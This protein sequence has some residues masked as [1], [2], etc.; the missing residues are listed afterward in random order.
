MTHLRRLLVGAAILGL[1]PLAIGAGALISTLLGGSADHGAAYGAAAL[2]FLACAYPLG[3][4][5][6][7]KDDAP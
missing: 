4:I 6:L 1:P 3:A 5:I 7:E 2:I